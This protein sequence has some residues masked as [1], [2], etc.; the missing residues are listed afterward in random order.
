MR[1]RLPWAWRGL[2]AATVA[3]Y[4]AGMTAGCGGAPGEAPPASQRPK[5]IATTS[6][7]GDVVSQVAGEDVAVRVLLPGETDPTGYSPSAADATAAAAAD[8]IFAAGAGFEPFLAKLAG[9]AKPGAVVELASDLPLRRR[10]DGGID[11]FVWLDPDLVGRWVDTIEGVLAK[12]DPGRA[13]TYHDHAQRYRLELAALDAMIEDI[14]TSLPDD[15]RLLVG[16]MAA[17]GY[18]AAGYGLEDGGAVLGAT[19]SPRAAGDLPVTEM[20]AAIAAADVPSVLIATPANRDRA[21]ELA[22]RSGVSLAPVWV[23][24]LSEP[25]GPAD[26]YLGLM[27]RLGIAVGQGWGEKQTPTP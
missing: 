6:I 14:A 20:A 19:S 16:D 15:R 4:V 27:R 26:S 13:A 9:T 12:A 18:F 22:N 24:G 11:P 23:L 1:H 3:L 10:G 2:A 8:A 17:F 25:G 21:L 7:V 5:V